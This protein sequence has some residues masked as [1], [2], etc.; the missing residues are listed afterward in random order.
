MKKTHALSALVGFCL[1][2]SVSTASARPTMA[3][4]GFGGGNFQLTNTFPD[5]NVGAGGGVA[6]D[7][8]FNQRWAIAASLSV[9]SHDGEGASQGDNGMLLLSVP[10]IDLK[11]YFFGQEHRIDP[12][13]TAGI[14]IGVLTGGSRSDNSGGAG[15][16]AQAGVG[17]DFY[18]NNW[19]SLG[20]LAQLKTVALIRNN[21]QSSA[22]IFL[23][24]V[25]NFAFHFK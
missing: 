22:L 13:A 3:V 17:S 9:F 6:F 21:S 23:T 2:F 18:L 11:F 24:T 14:G 16:G 25:G 5:L 7:Y 19:F 15:L 20:F 12:Y 8:R 4:S 1:L 10:D